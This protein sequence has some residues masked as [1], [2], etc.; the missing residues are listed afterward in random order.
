M[1][2]I[3]IVFTDVVESSATKRDVS[4]GRDSRE[5]D[6]AY[7][8]KVQTRHF[9][10]IRGCC[11]AHG[12]KEIS[13]MG[14][15]FY[16][17]FEDP[18]EAVRCA[19]SIQKRLVEDP[20]ETP[21]GPLRLRVGI[22]SGF[23]ESF[24]GSLHGT[25]VDAAARVEA[26][27]TAEQILLS[28]RTYE[29]VR[30]MTDVKFHPRGE[31]ALKGVDRMLL[32][33]AA[34]DDRGPRPTAAR[35][36]SQQR[37]RKQIQIAATMLAAAILVVGAAGYRFYAIRKAREAAGLPPTVMPRRSVAVLGFKNL[38]G[39]SAAYI[40]GALS[41]WFATEL[42]AGERLRAI[43]SENVE[44]ARSDLSLP[45]A[46]GYS[47]ET[48]T[49]IRKRLGADDVIAGSYLA[50][51]DQPSEQIRLDVR[52]QDTVACVTVCAVSETGSANNLFDLVSKA[53]ADLRQHLGVGPVTKEQAASVRAA[54]PS[55]PEAGRLY[56]EG[57]KK[58]RVFDALGARGLLQKAVAAEPNYALAH[59]ELAA[60]WSTLGYDQ[61]SRDEAKKAFDLASSLSREEQ[62]S[63]E[64]RYHESI[65]DWN[66]AI[67]T[68]RTLWRFFPDD[69]EFGL[70]LAEV[71][72]NASHGKDALLTIGELRKLPPPSCDDPR[73]D[74]AA[75]RINLA[76]GDLKLGQEAAEAAAAKG[77]SQGARLV[78]A[79]AEL[80]QSEALQD[81]GRTKEAIQAGERARKIFTEAGD[82][83]G[84]ASALTS[85]GSLFLTTGDISQAK[86][87]WE[88]SLSISREI[89][90]ES[91]I[92]TSLSNLSILLGQAGDLAGEQ[93]LLEQ[94]LEIARKIGDTT[95]A[96][97]VTNSLAGILYRK[98]DLR[99]AERMEEST[100]E[101]Y[102]LT[103]ARKEAAGALSNL[104]MIMKGEGHLDGARAKY[105]EALAIYRE[106]GMSDGVASVTN[107][108]GNLL[109]EESKLPD[110]KAMFERALSSF[111]EI[112][113][114]EGM[115]ETR[116][117]L[118]NVLYDLGDL[119]GAR[120]MYEQS[121]AMVR[122]TQ[123][124]GEIAQALKNLG[125]VI[126]SQGDLAGA[127]RMQEEC[128]Q[129]RR[130]IGVKGDIA[131]SQFELAILSINEG[132]PAAAEAPARAAAEEFRKEQTP[133]DE[134]SALGVLARAQ[135]RQGKVAAAE[136]T[137]DSAVALVEKNK[138]V[139]LTMPV[140][141][142]AARIHAAAGKAGAAR[143][144]LESLLAQTVQLGN[145][146]LQFDARLALGEVEIKLGMTTSGRARLVEL[147]KDATAR[148]F[149]LVAR[150]A[151][152]A[153]KQKAVR[154]TG[155]ILPS[156]ELLSRFVGNSDYG[157]RLHLLSTLPQN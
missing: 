38:G 102:R 124:N 65:N 25:D 106:M 104:A 5:R 148:G 150:E 120:K 96:A 97:R 2:L 47:S 72:Y 78:V 139:A 40:S 36:L 136:K 37:H 67:E 19:A 83:S 116:N 73:I 30:H 125:E 154:L 118:G 103:G 114:K 144:S 64:A 146:S 52:M 107:S 18:V 117:N 84:V 75:A 129:I 157:D 147:Q 22:H 128:L 61:K 24:E 81:L 119:P 3:T 87:S 143:R 57:V 66:G 133:L 42:T 131:D 88:E 156:K 35:P 135:L 29:L 31:F 142:A 11:Q 155:H 134:A 60:A 74:L 132:N 152:A 6:H 34:W 89:G 122:E 153:L 79:Q 123:N 23:P 90:H 55:D 137:I 56:A 98:G 43:P 105:E 16:L 76:L 149:L 126:E 80:C 93:R 53:G 50:M 68:Y 71:Q 51:G 141:I 140:L 20:I 12:G 21:R 58:L 145:I 127:R 91:A 32:W 101:V 69:I 112:G 7:L 54:F 121:L 26:T 138:S 44:R 77:E 59:S 70:R 45:E 49:R 100:L 110:A 62:L 94:S 109:Y 130:Q 39:P 28:A 14:D 82:Q 46:N 99:G 48:L 86:R 33:E 151:E 1:A 8:E 41:D 95:G 115:L 9:N 15:A 13:T 108:L 111:T 17:T 92:K 85:L 4:L 27:A 10:L 113:D 63:I